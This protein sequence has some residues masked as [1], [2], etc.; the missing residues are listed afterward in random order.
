MLTL[1][2]LLEALTGSSDF[3]PLHTVERGAGGEVLNLPI[4]EVVIDSREAVPDALFVALHGEHTDGHEYVN[5]AF[6]RGAIA[7]LVERAPPGVDAP[8]L[9]LAAPLDEAALATAQPPVCLR[10]PSALEA[11]QRFAACWRARF[12]PRVV[13]VTGSVGKTSTKELIAAVLERRFN[14]FKSE[15]NLNSDIGLP[16]ALL[17]LRPEHERA[18]LEM[19]MYDV[20]EIARLCE[21]A[22]PAVGVVTMVGPVHLERVGSMEGIIAAK[23]ELVQ[24][25][26]AEAD[27]GVA[28]LNADDPNVLGMRRKTRA[29]VVTYGLAHD[30][31]VRASEVTGLGLEGIRF[32]LH[33]GGEAFSV[34]V[35][36]LGRHSA[37]TA[38]RAA[39][40]GLVEGMTW[41]EILAGLQFSAVQLRL[42]AISGPGGSV[43]LD[44]TYNASPDSTFA[45]LNLLAELEGRRVAVLGDML[46][47]GSYEEAGHRMVGARAREV[48]DLLVTV[49]PRGRVIAAAALDAGMPA[50]IVHS[51]DMHLEAIDFLMKEVRAGDYVLVKGSRAMHMDKI[52]E[53]MSQPTESEPRRH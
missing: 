32:R 23:S 50:G 2:C 14:T 26:P 43:L 46:E 47:L 7:A 25:L 49:G 8:V 41:D 28:I 6:A 10:V 44:D 21:I 40:V 12:T 52:V 17:K 4:S 29:R 15:G 34:K 36:L 31:D 18:V 16:L 30:A 24:A 9:D 37:H 48:A 33:C 20:G 51:F 45:A 38:L 22:R 13:G 42:M 11:L 53:V 1:G 39:A 35:P 19:G 5:D 3:P 27:G